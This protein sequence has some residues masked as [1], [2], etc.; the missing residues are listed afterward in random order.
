MSVT[1]AL[2]DR[3][4]HHLHNCIPDYKINLIYELLPR[5][6]APAAAP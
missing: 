3:I 2:L 5:N 4:T 6:T 1:A